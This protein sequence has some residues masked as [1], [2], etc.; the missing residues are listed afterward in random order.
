MVKNLSYRLHYINKNNWSSLPDNL[1]LYIYCNHVMV[2][3]CFGFDSKQYVLVLA[4]EFCCERREGC[5]GAPLQ[6]NLLLQFLITTTSWICLRKDSTLFMKMPQKENISMPIGTKLK[7]KKNKLCIF[8]AKNGEVIGKRGT[9][10]E[11]TKSGFFPK[12]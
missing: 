5:G 7:N 1:K 4:W 3:C 10:H 6:T 11:I 2:Q 12:L 8:M 9:K